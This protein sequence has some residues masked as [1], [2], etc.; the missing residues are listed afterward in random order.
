[1]GLLPEEGIRSLLV[2]AAPLFGPTRACGGKQ[3]GGRIREE[4]EKKRRKEGKKERKNGKIFQTWKFPE[5]KIKDN[6]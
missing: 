6:L 5:R 2:V 1:V 4:R 3:E